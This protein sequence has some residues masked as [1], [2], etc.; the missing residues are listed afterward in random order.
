MSEKAAS[1]IQPLTLIDQNIGSKIWVIMKVRIP[2]LLSKRSGGR[3]AEVLTSA[4]DAAR[5]NLSI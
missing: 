1:R 4:L 2:L 3:Q 5:M